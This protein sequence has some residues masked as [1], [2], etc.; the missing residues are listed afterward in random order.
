M[1]F[2]FTAFSNDQIN[3]LSRHLKLGIKT[4]FSATPEMYF[5]FL[6]SEVKC[7]EEAL[8]IADRQN[9]H[10][11][12]VAI[13][14]IVELYRQVERVEELHRQVL[15]FSISH[16]H[17]QVRIYAHYPEIESLNTKCYRHTL[18]EF[19]ITDDDGKERWT[20]YH[21]V[22]NVYDSFIPGHFQRIKSAV[23][24]LPDP[25]LE[26]FQ[27]T[28]STENAESSQALIASSATPSQE[29]VG[30]FKKPALPKRGSVVDLRAQLERQ[31]QEAERQRQESEKLR[32]EFRHREDRLMDELK[33]Q[34]A[35][36]KQEKDQMQAQLTRLIEL[37]TQE[38]KR[39]SSDTASLRNH[40]N[41]KQ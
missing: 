13:R 29:E 6:T 39:P 22:R 28:Q 10:S 23:D 27:S 17:R 12:T 18:R 30:S 35:E 3:K 14:G 1:G 40:S 8:N 11:M 32:E 31:S 9:A 34:R 19:I 24:Q 36:A 38:R 16:D 2:R 25:V 21:F 20:A 4:Y 26:S 15:G 37:L 5:P 41:L 7:G 33:Q